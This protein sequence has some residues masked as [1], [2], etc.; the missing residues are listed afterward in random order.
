MISIIVPV[1]NASSVIGRLI[2]CFKK[3]SYKDFEVLFVDNNS[4]DN[5]HD[6]LIEEAKKDKKFRILKEEKQGPN[7]ARLKGFIESKGEYIYFCDCDDLLFKDTL[8]NLITTIEQ[9][10]SDIVIAD[11]CEI[12][13]NEEI[14]KH[15]KGI[16]YSVDNPQ[17]IFEKEKTLFI[18][19]PLWNKIF[20]KNIIK[21]DYFVF[22]NI[23]EDMLLSLSSISSTT[24]I[25]YLN[26]EVY[27]YTVSNEG[28]SYRVTLEN[29]IGIVDTCKAMNVIF[30]KYFNNCF[31]DEI[32]YIQ[33]QHLLYR[34]LRSVLLDKENRSEARDVLI[35]YIV[36]IKIRTNQYFRHSIP[37]RCAY[38]ILMNSFL[39]NI[40]LYF[41]RLLFTNS[42]FSKMFKKLD[43]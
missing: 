23:G 9:N 19:L 32:K 26:K 18:K 35:P 42:L 29:I 6:I 41:M 28:L 5:S 20:K 8:E 1:Y 17:N 15:C 7:Y 4:T 39:Y 24:K 14:I 34:L 12:N 22:T 30:S 10:N 37:Y 43:K 3:Q 40:S 38:F 16:N 13:Q 25:C 27:K 21:K 33:I 11:Y 31:D 2:D 36:S